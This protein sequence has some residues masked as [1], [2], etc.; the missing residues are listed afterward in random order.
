[1]KKL[2]I[3]C[4]LV[5]CSVGTAV[6][7]NSNCKL[8][9]VN[10]VCPSDYFTEIKLASTEIRA[11][12]Y[13]SSDI[14]LIFYLAVPNSKFDP[15]KAGETIMSAYVKDGQKF[16]WK[17]LPEP[18]EMDTKT[19][20]KYE[21]ISHLGLSEKMLIEVKAFLFT[22]RGKKIVLGY[23]TD[24]SESTSENKRL[25]ESG[26]PLGGSGPGCNA[27]VTVLNSITKEFR[28]KEQYCTLTVFSTN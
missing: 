5:I 12:K 8:G 27:V 21:L 9:T 1:M 6:A 14:K 26:Q 25:F 18:F 11:F 10:F 17:Q 3:L 19:K 15:A 13:Q 28:G 7:Q 2:G 23:I 20:Y 4:F 22:I 24:W 16:K